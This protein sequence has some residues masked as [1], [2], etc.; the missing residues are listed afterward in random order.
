[1]CCVC[2]NFVLKRL[3]SGFVVV[4]RCCCGSKIIMECVSTWLVGY[5]C[6]VGKSVLIIV[7]Y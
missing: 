4:L 6:E 3:R 1:M 5:V 7:V 2:C